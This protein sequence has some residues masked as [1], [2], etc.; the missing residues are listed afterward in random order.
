MDPFNLC[1][2]RV[3][4]R[5]FHLPSHTVAGMVTLSGAQFEEKKPRS[6]PRG[7]DRFL[8][9]LSALEAAMCDRLGLLRGH[10]KTAFYPLSGVDGGIVQLFPEARL[11]IGIDDHPF[12]QI[13][14]DG[15]TIL[16]H[17]SPVEAFRRTEEISRDQT[18]F[19]I[20]AGQR[21]IGAMAS[22]VPNFRLLEVTVFVTEENVSISEKDRLVHGLID[23]DSGPGTPLRRYL[24]VNAKLVRGLN[25]KTSWWFRGLDRW[26][27][28]A[29]IIKGAQGLFYPSGNE[30]RDAHP[31]RR[32]ILKWL[33]WSRG[34]LIEGDNRAS[35]PPV[36]S[37]GVDDLEP[38]WELSEDERFENTASVILT[39]LLYGYSPGGEVKITKF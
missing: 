28:D 26:V 2:P 31:L 29:V 38:T 10:V 23:F 22:S 39:G 16:I 21:V 4:L 19:G 14:A 37:Y 5:P 12:L 1:D 11:L 20:F 33:R 8:H 3:K 30:S 17:R 13:P 6:W 15:E 9:T 27:P 18:A 24:H 32:D 35:M 7:H 36:Y 25:Y 34:Y